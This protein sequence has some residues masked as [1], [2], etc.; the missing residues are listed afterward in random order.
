M[1]KTALMITHK[2]RPGKRDEVRA[3]WEKHLKPEPDYP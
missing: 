1:S 2:A 3:T